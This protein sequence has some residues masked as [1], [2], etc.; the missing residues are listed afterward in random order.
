M[1]LGM[2]RLLSLGA[3]I[4]PAVGFCG[5]HTHL[6]ARAEEGEV[7]INTF[8]YFGSIGPE[9]WSTLDAA[10]GLCATGTRQSPINMAEGQFHLV[11]SS[12]IAL[13]VPDLAAGEAE[14]ENL[15]TTVEVVLEGRGGA[16]TLAGVE[17]ELKQFHVHHPSEHLD[18]G[19]SVEMEVHNV[20]ESAD[21]QLA[22]IG[23]YVESDLGS[24][25]D[26]AAGRKRSSRRQENAAP[27]PTNFTIMASSALPETDAITSPLLEAVFAQVGEVAAP[28]SKTAVAAPLVFSEYVA[29]LMAGSFQAYSG[30]L[31][32]PPC[33][34][35]VNWL[36]ATQRLKVSPAAVR[37]VSDVVKFNSRITQNLLGEPNILDVAARNSAAVVRGDDTAVAVPRV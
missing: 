7:K 20:F 37:R 11:G 24:I 27:P 1:A 23:V 2:A 3:L 34:E 17:Y 9:N 21:G 18:D 4:A 12:D 26:V 30:S 31:T 25:V 15:G 28:G 19:A 16:L 35:G 33:S 6:S 22:V 5:S 32:T 13:E 14:L 29:A 10:N 36:V 8:G